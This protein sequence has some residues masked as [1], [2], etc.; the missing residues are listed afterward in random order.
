VCQLLRLER[1]FVIVTILVEVRICITGTVT[2]PRLVVSHAPMVTSN[3]A[4]RPLRSSSYSDRSMSSPSGRKTGSPDTCRLAE[5]RRGIFQALWRCLQALTN[6]GVVNENV[7]LAV[8]PRSQLEKLG[9]VFASFYVGAYIGGCITRTRDASCQSFKAMLSAR[10]KYN[11]RNL[12]AVKVT[13]IV[14]SDDITHRPG[15]AASLKPG[16]SIVPPKYFRSFCND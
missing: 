15:S 7:K 2:N 16:L 8:R 11:L 4:F 14:A 9:C 1:Y 6:A 10:F 3:D 12:M 13:D 5:R